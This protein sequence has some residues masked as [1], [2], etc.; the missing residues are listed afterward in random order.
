MVRSPLLMNTPPSRLST[1]TPTK[2]TPAALLNSSP[3]SSSFSQATYIRA[4]N[5]FFTV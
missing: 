4:T 3:T 2:R 1:C 5:H